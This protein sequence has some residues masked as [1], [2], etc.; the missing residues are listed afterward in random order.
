MVVG[1]PVCIH[2]LFMHQK[3]AKFQWKKRDAI[4]PLR[5]D[6]RSFLSKKGELCL[7]F[8]IEQMKGKVSDSTF[9][10][11][12][13]KRKFFLKAVCFNGT[14]SQFETSDIQLTFQDLKLTHPRINLLTSTCISI[15]SVKIQQNVHTPE[16]F[17]SCPVC[18]PN[19]LLPKTQQ[20]QMSFCLTCARRTEN[21]HFNR[22][23]VFF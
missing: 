22:I 11:C 13:S 3:S 12:Q 7:S 21:R 1:L 20:C 16:Q 10:E 4:L 8:F 19:F 14:K 9:V 23:S 5:F 17:I 6:H 2:A 15:I 18:N